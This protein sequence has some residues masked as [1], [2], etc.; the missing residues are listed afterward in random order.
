[1]NTGEGTPIPRRKEASMKDT[2]IITLYNQ[3]D[4]R[5]IYETHQ[6][7]GDYCMSISSASSFRKTSRHPTAV[8][9][10]SLLLRHFLI[11]R[12]DLLQPMV[13]PRLGHG[14][15]VKLR[16]LGESNIGVVQPQT[17]GELKLLGE[18]G[19]QIVIL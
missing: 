7:Y 15:E 10:L 16:Q 6:K 1:M 11:K 4:E 14:R 18:G 5:A 17:G 12:H 2:D 13:H 19:D 9:C 8:R 3:R